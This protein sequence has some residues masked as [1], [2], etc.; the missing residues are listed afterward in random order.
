M[1]SI[2]NTQR[3]SEVREKVD[4]IID[5]LKIKDDS[6]YSSLSDADI[7]SADVLVSDFAVE[8][9][10]SVGA[11]QQYIVELA[12]NVLRNM[13]AFKRGGK[14]RK[15]HKTRKSHKSRKHHTYRKYHK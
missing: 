13:T 6:H 2:L 15:S 14:H 4:S 1:A 11:K 5:S 3:I 7:K 9:F 8:T 12:Y 10:S